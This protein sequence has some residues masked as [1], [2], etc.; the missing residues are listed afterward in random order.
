VNERTVRNW[1]H[2]EGG[3]SGRPP[4]SPAERRRAFVLVVRTWR[5][6]GRRT[7]WRPI[8]RE[9][10]GVVPVRLVQECLSAAKRL[11]RSHAERSRVHVGVLARNAMWHVDATHLGR[12]PSG[13]VQ[14]QILRDGATPD[15]L[16]ASA[17]GAVTAHDAQTL[18]RAAIDA[19]GTAPL[20][21]ST[22]N[23][24]PYTATA[25]EVLLR[26][27]K[28]VHLKNLPHTPQHNAKVER[29]IRDVKDHSG[30]GKGV[31]IA[32]TADVLGPL[33][34]ACAQRDRHAG[35]PT[36]P[37]CAY[38]GTERERFYESLCRDVR[39][40]V[41]CKH[42]ARAQRI[43]EREAIHAELERRGLIQRTRGG[44]RLA[45]SK[46]EINS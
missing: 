45:P 24:P 13:E 41:R 39:N 37:S 9:L 15:V 33:K 16:A 22:D 10:R 40:A 28:I 12:S 2:S 14:A 25:F 29:T 43:A 44:A 35:R 26:R 20:V 42:G 27:H 21:L 5:R 3:R 18:L 1:L 32:R 23:G 19:A 11:H 4:R 38:T 8:S 34:R 17:G 36:V 30:L 31:R 7:G 46:P 6:L